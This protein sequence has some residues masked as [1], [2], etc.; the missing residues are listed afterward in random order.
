M[1][2]NEDNEA[3]A[4]ATLQYNRNYVI[5]MMI[6]ENNFDGKIDFLE[7]FYSDCDI[8]NN[9]AT[10]FVEVPTHS[11]GILNITKDNATFTFFEGAYRR[12]TEDIADILEELKRLT[13]TTN[14]GEG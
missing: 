8:S 3:V 7:T 5:G 12:T 10:Y 9:T 1:S 14:D 2:I 11:N 13:V 6:G 4:L